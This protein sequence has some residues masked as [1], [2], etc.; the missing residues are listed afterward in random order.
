MGRG[1]E[2]YPL[3]DGGAR[4]GILVAPRVH[5]STADAYLRLSPRCLWNPNKI[6]WLVSSRLYGRWAAR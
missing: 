6:K 5:V 4:T 2:L 3:P 1:T